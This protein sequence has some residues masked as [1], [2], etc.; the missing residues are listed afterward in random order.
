MRTY[1]IQMGIRVACFLGAY[2]VDGWLRWA[3]VAAAVFLPYI[4]V[5]GA[6]TGKTNTQ[7]TG[8]PMEY[9]QLEAQHEAM[10]KE[11]ENPSH[12]DEQ[13]EKQQ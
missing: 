4:A 5:V 11:S 2:F 13:Q 12:D 3:L 7:D 9:L 1:L 8:N 6:N 10:L